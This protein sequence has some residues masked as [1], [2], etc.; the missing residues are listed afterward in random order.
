M[1]KKV[2]HVPKGIQKKNGPGETQ[3][4][5]S[6]MHSESGICISFTAKPL[7]AAGMVK[8]KSTMG[9]KEEVTYGNDHDQ[10]V[11]T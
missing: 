6:D 8:D 7:K 5:L 2:A 10:V 4:E 11:Y 1:Q 9:S 3:Q